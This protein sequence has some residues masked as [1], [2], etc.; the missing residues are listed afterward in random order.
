MSACSQNQKRP[1]RQPQLK[2]Y[3]DIKTLTLSM[4]IDDVNPDSGT[5]SP[6]I[7]KTF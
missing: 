2:M 6:T 7:N 5:P 1:Y 4:S 3:G